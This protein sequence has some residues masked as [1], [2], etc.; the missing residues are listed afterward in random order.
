MNIDGLKLQ[1]PPRL[2]G[3]RLTLTCKKLIVGDTLPQNT[4]V[5]DLALIRQA[6]GDSEDTA[7]LVDG[8]GIGSCLLYKL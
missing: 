7:H 4:S 6:L 1:T 5:R 2:Y 8:K 3:M